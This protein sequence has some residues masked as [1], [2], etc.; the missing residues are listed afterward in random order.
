L[1]ISYEEELSDR[2]LAILELKAKGL[3]QVEI[4]KQLG[5]S[6]A[7]VSKSFSIIRAKARE[8]LTNHYQELPL[9]YKLVIENLEQI[10]REAWQTVAH[11][12]D[13]RSKSV[14]FN[15]LISVNRE[16][17]DV[18]A[19]GDL[20]EQE[21]GNAELIQKQAQD[22]IKRVKEKLAEQGGKTHPQIGGFDLDNSIST[23][24]QEES[25]EIAVVVDSEEAMA[26][27]VAVGEDSSREVEE[28]EGEEDSGSDSSSGGSTYEIV[29]GDGVV[30]G[31]GSSDSSSG[32]SG[33]VGS[34]SSDSSDSDGDSMIESFETNGQRMKTKNENDG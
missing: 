28:V 20:I 30:S 34:D 15:T 12:Q 1:P 18:I 29:G 33:V 19:A 7:A 4:A 3:K 16:I 27:A 11:T 6:E 5:V 14:L 24:Q 23:S 21:V 25:K 13:A 10:R 22:D 8:E 31:E 26:L 17:L 32:S 9:R 2:R